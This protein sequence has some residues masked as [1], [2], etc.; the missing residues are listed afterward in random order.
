MAGRIPLAAAF[1]LAAALAAAGAARSEPRTVEA[2]RF[3]LLDAKGAAR[4]ALE[5][6]EGGNPRLV[7]RDAEGRERAA[8]ALD[9]EGRPMVSLHD[10]AGQPRTMIGPTSATL[11]T[12]WVLDEGGVPRVTLGATPAG[13]F[14][15]FLL[16]AALR[17]RAHLSLD[18]D[19]VHL[20]LNDVNQKNRL[21]LSVLD[22]GSTG[23][24][25]RDTK[26][27]ARAGL[28]VETDDCPHLALYGE[29]MKERFLAESRKDGSTGISLCDP[30]GRTLLGLGVSPKNDAGLNVFDPERKGIRMTLG[31]RADGKSSLAFNGGETTPGETKPLVELGTAPDLAPGGKGVSFL[32]LRNPGGASRIRLEAMEGGLASVVVADSRSSPVAA[33]SA[34]AAGRVG[35]ALVGQDHKPRALL[36][37]R[38]DAAEE[39]EAAT[40]TLFDAKGKVKTKLP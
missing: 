31:A 3:V 18:G 6:S 19:G 23:V 27:T 14:G 5:S 34:D 37:V 2:E 16:D 7:L 22:R 26:E 12:V 10:G 25:L 17:N 40:F 39:A 36:E 1:V 30:Q 13:D 15:L 20:D 11:G 9:G 35:L 8:V 21:C 33:L 28:V 24:T 29:G 38:T 4:A 32:A